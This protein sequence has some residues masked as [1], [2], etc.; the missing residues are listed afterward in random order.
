MML[1]THHGDSNHNGENVGCAP[2]LELVQRPVIIRPTNY[3]VDLFR[4]R[5]KWRVLATDFGIRLFFGF[6]TWLLSSALSKCCQVHQA[7]SIIP[8][9][10]HVGAPEPQRVVFSNLLPRTRSVVPALG[11]RR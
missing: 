1:T 9:P 4:D 5:R 3:R 10:F 11:E 2:G 8:V 7:R 6:T